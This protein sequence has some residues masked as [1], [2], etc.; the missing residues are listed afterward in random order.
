[1]DVEVTI[2]DK[3]AE[4]GA[5]SNQVCFIVDIAAE[6]SAKVQNTKL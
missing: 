5:L 3:K 6:P 2:L 4:L 1:M